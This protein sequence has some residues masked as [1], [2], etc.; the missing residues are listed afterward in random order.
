M[1]CCNKPIFLQAIE[2]T[3]AI[4]I[5]KDQ[6]P[7]TVIS[8]HSSL[9][10]NIHDTFQELDANLRNIGDEKA[11]KGADLNAHRRVWG[12]RNEDQRGMQVEDFLLGH[13]SR[14]RRHSNKHEVM[15]KPS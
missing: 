4:K 8:A 2:H 12:Y 9:Y 10:N 14:A 11:L 5:Q 6:G 15:R 1:P 3:S 7:L 13:P